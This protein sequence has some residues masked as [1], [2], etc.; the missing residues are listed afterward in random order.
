MSEEDLVIYVATLELQEYPGYI[1]EHFNR[2]I[3]DFSVYIVSTLVFFSVGWV[4]FSRKLFQNY[5]VKFR[6]VQA[7]FS[8]VF[9][10]ACNMFSLVIFEITDFTDRDSR[11]ISWRLD[12]VSMLIMLILIIPP[13]AFYLFWS[14]HLA[15]RKRAM[16]ATLVMF[17]MFLYAFYKVGEPFPITSDDLSAFSIEQGVSRVGVIGVTSMAVLSGFGAVNAPYSNLNYFLRH[18]SDQELQKLSKRILQALE[19]ILTLRKKL[20][21]IRRDMENLN[22]LKDFQQH[23][24]VC[25][26]LV[27]FLKRFCSGSK[28][29]NSLKTE[30]EAINAEIS[31]LQQVRR[32][33]F[34]EMNDLNNEKHRVRKSKR[35]KGKFFNC[36]GY[37]FSV[38]CVYKM[39]MASVNIIFQRVMKRDAISRGIELFVLHIWQVELDVEFWSQNISFFLVGCIVV[40]QMRGFLLFFLRRFRAWSTV[41][42]SNSIILLLVEMMG[43]YFIASILLMRMNV[44][45]QYRRIITSALGEVEF[46]FYHHWFD[47]IFILS[48]I[49]TVAL[50]YVN[51]NGGT[52]Q[53]HKLSID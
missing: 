34:D 10:T 14:S 5:E 6:V 47:V 29:Y 33:L 4:L 2:L 48:A 50:L 52:K 40:T 53:K 27:R 3:V 12:I 25:S 23:T 44:P 32:E 19:R 42:S 31:A 43:M 18:T 20:H 35:L 7:L 51:H 49:S 9:S 13:V 11:W 26:A 21:W 45:L 16:M 28:R 15:S 8:M 17:I 24:G 1:T 36:M 46:H 39:V 30:E 38:Y 37:F 22:K 41:H